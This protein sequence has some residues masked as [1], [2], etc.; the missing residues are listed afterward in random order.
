[1]S[2]PRSLGYSF[3]IALPPAVD[4]ILRRWTATTPGATWDASGGHV[5]VARFTGDL[6]PADLVPALQAAC[7]GL[8]SFPIAFCAPARE[9]YWDKPGLEIVM[10][11]GGN[12]QDVAG[13]FNLR[14]HLLASLSPVDVELLESGAFLPH[15]TLTTGL[16]HEEAMALETAAAGLDLRFTAREV[17]LWSGGETSE[18]SE[19]AEPPWRPIQSVLLG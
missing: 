8:A 9:A 1:M 16:P 10:L 15:I 7:E 14:E 2:T 4:L 11:V 19:E 12:A 17:V 18:D 13:V 5:T 3:L 6:S